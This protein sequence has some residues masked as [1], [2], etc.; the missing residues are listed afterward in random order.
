MEF[1][2][3]RLVLIAHLVDRVDKETTMKIPNLVHVESILR[4]DTKAQINGKWV[5]ARPGPFYSIYA[6][7]YCAWLVLTGKCDALKW[8][9]GQ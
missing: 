9:E 7:W 6:R 4:D 8:P 2:V 1:G 5:P 3:V